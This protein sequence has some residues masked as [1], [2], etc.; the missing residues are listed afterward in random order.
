C[1]S[2]RKLMWA[3]PGDTALR[4]TSIPCWTA[5]QAGGDR[6]FVTRGRN[7]AFYDLMTGAR[8]PLGSTQEKYP[9][10]DSDG[11]R[12]AWSGATCR[13]AL[14]NVAPV[15]ELLTTPFRAGKPTCP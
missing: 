6:L 1:D 9:A 3:A 11:E 4:P 13:T 10:F 8:Q 12:V 5:A 14:V 7:V 15:S 2:D